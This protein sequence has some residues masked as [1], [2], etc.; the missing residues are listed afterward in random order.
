[1]LPI[2]FFCK[3]YFHSFPTGTSSKTNFQL[4]PSTL[5]LT[6]SLQY[7]VEKREKTA[8]TLVIRTVS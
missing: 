3:T 7:N 4:H 1:M 2:L 5:E 6:F 8:S